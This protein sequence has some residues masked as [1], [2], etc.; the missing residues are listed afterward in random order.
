MD[1]VFPGLKHNAGLSNN[2]FRALVKKMHITNVTPHGFRSTF[3][4]W[5]SEE[6]FQFSGET[7]GIPTFIKT[8]LELTARR[9]TRASPRAMVLWE[10]YINSSM[11]RGVQEI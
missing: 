8:K 2:A 3:R 11:M 7:V 10:R 6:A 9:P 4:D 1:H 5:A